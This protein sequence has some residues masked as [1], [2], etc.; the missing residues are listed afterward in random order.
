MDQGTR[1]ALRDC[2]KGKRFTREVLRRTGIPSEGIAEWLRT[3]EPPVEACGRLIPTA[4]ALGVPL[5][6]L[7]LGADRHGF[8]EA[9]HEIVLFARL[10]ADREWQATIAE[11]S[12]PGDPPSPVVPLTVPA[13]VGRGRKQDVFSSFEHELRHHILASLASAQVD[14]AL[15]NHDL[16]P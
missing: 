6:Q 13:R 5:D 16:R 3:G 9:G 12:P 11:W 1:H 2:R 4:H 14:D 10:T 8:S 7:D 15:E